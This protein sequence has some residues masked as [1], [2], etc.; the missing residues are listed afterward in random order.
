MKEIREVKEIISAHM[1]VL[2]EKY[3]VKTM[4]IFGSYIRG[5]QRESSDI[6]ILVEFAR[7]V[8]LFTFIELEDYLSNLLGIKVDLVLKDGIKPALKDYILREMISL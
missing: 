2:T 4:G 8:G 1:N 7:P 3:Y 5:E 6:D